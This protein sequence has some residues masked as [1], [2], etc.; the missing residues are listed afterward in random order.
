MATSSKP[1]ARAGAY[2]AGSSKNS[3]SLTRARPGGQNP[4][5]LRRASAAVALYKQ[6]VNFRHD[7]VIVGPE[8]ALR[9]CGCFQDRPHRRV[10]RE[11]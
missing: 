5:Q 8:P 2:R 1:A 9:D 3:S 6:G 11:L 4:D 7:D 10:W